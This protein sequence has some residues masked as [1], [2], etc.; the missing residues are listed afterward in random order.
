[1]AAGVGAAL[2]GRRPIVEIMYSDFALLA[3]D[4]IANQAAMLR[5]TFGGQFDV[6]LVVRSTSGARGGGGAQ[7]SQSLETLF[8]QIPGL[9][10][11]VPATP[12]DARALLKASAASP[13]PT[14]FLEHKA[15][16]THRGLVDNDPL[17]L[18]RACVARA[19]TDSTIVATQLLLHRSMDAADRLHAEDIDLEIIDLRT[20]WPLD[21]EAIYGSVRRTRRLLICHE[22]PLLLGFGAELAAQTQQELWSELH[23]PVAR[24]GAARVPTPYSPPLKAALVPSVDEIV[25]TARALVH[26]R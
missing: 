3:F 18:G 11:V 25:L 20:L 13:N 12:N 2:R 15:L 23:A 19:G 22:A 1:V 7:H 8:A 24:L 21:I 17:E 6:P 4:P 10:V 26:G 14:I 9:E 5:Y 16:Y